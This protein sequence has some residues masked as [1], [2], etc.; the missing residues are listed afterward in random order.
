MASGVGMRE[1]GGDTPSCIKQFEQLNVVLSAPCA[2]FLFR[3]PCPPPKF[4]ERSDLFSQN[5]CTATI[6]FEP[7][8][9][10]YTS[11]FPPPCFTRKTTKPPTPP[12]PVC[13]PDSFSKKKRRNQSWEGKE[14]FFLFP[15]RDKE[16]HIV[17]I[18][19]FQ[20]QTKR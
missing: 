6:L 20:N 5:S 4:G 3:L 2:K 16:D 8:P 11:N 10:P 12:P 1:Q 15:R 7:H 17:E 14:D 18:P 19:T 13:S 9:F